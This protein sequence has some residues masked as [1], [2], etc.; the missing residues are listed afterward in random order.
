M[1]SAHAACIGGGKINGM[2]VPIDRVPQNGEIVEILTSSSSKGPSRD[3]IKIVNT[4]EARNKIKQW[5]KK[6]CREENILRAVDHHAVDERRA[7]HARLPE[8]EVENVVESEGDEYS[9]DK[10]VNCRADIA[11]VQNKIAESEYPLLNEGP[12]EEHKRADSDVND[13]W[14]D[15]H[16]ARAAKKGDDGGQFDLVKSV[17]QPRHTKANDNAAEH[18]HL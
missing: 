7:A 9:L 1:G 4:G 16:E 3:W 6:E 2:I 18:T 11:R 10:T 12:D 15:R 13:G 8:G 17:V 14:N 5:F